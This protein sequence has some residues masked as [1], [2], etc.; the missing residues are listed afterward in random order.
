M[1]TF[2]GR[3]LW[4][5]LPDFS[6][7]LWSV[8]IF[9]DIANS[10]GRFVY[11]EEKSLRWNNKRLAWVLVEMDLELGFPNEIEISLG[12]SSFMDSLDYW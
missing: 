11:F 5:L 6:L 3:F 4:I 8:R 7:E 10:V 1:D 12:D 2:S 9:I